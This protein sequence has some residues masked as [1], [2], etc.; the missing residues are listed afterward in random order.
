MPELE[1]N[2]RQWSGWKWDRAGEEWSD[3]WGSTEALW[4]WTLRPRI[5][6]WVPA[7]AILEIAPGFGRWTD[8]LKDL[9]ERL[10]AVDLSETCI[11]ACRKRFAGDPHVELHVNDGRSLDMVED[12]SIDFAFSF[13]SLV[14]VEQDVIESYLGELA[15]VLRP[16]GVAFLHHSNFGAY[17]RGAAI[18]RRVPYRVR[19]RLVRRGVVVNVDAWRAD[20]SAESFA[21]AAEAAGLAC[22]SQ[23]KIS[24]HFGGKLLDVL[25]VV[26]PRGSSEERPPLVVEN[27]EFSGE[28]ARVARLAPLYERPGPPATPSRR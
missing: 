1:E 15:R 22:I 26:T 28:P 24:W 4:R 11:D 14:H 25:S 18:A 2:R 19:Q 17:R 3:P 20:V 12:G 16:N 13:D 5:Q 23:E 8:Y 7:P 6:S 21:R 10:I 27:P 9:S